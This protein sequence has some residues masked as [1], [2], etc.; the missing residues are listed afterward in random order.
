DW[1]VNKL[2]ELEIYK[3]SFSKYGRAYQNFVK[4]QVESAGRSRGSGRI[5]ISGISMVNN[6]I[7]NRSV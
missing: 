2:S 5:Y 4:S 6:S 1:L 3:T 7:M